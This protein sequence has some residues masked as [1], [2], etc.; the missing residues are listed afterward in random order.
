M[1]VGKRER[2]RIPFPVHIPLS[3]VTCFAAVLLVVELY[4]GT[5]PTFAICAFLFIFVSGIT[6]NLAGG[7]S[8]TSG[9]YVF[10]YAVLA[11]IVG[12]CWK[13]VLREP[14]D[15]NLMEPN[16]TMQIYLGSMVALLMAVAISKKLTP[17]RPL[18][19]NLLKDTTVQNATVGCLVTG[20][21]VS[22]LL[23]ILPRQEGSILSALAQ[24]NRFLPMAIILGVVHEIQVSGGKRSI[25]LPVLLSAG[26][27]FSM[28]LI[29]FSKEGLFTPVACWL[30]AAGS[31]AFR[32]SRLQIAGVA[33]GLYLMIHFLVP[34]AQYGRN[35][36]AETLS[37][38]VDLAIGF[39]G[40]LERIRTEYEAS[41]AAAAEDRIQGYFNTSQGFMDRLQM[42]SVDDGLTHVTEQHGAFGPLP[43]LMGFENLVP[44]FL[45]PGKPAINFGNLYAHEMGGLSADDFT[46]GISFSPAG[47]AYHIG[48][49]FGVFVWA[50]L[51]WILLFVVFDSLCGDTRVAPWGLLICAYYTHMAPEGMLGGIIYTL[52]FVTAGLV[53]AALSAAYVMPILG[54]LIKGPEKV[55]LRRV[56]PVRS[57]RRAGPPLSQGAQE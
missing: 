57:I 29:G 49:W 3:R 7:F 8:R 4:Q 27:L 55:S 44:R 34:Y 33:F 47:E 32:P 43:L 5:S 20:L 51:L 28:G 26:V 31:Q 52:G 6:F 45:W 40:D 30:V 13:A 11:V 10:C 39:L 37:E 21:S 1:E 15:S 23:I 36:P 54:S 24:V 42:I 38:R 19:G 18:L 41:S 14:A 48:K 22:A 46:T 25:N 53:F 9:A 35:F 2:V 17:K 12:L 16:L 50:P 56:A